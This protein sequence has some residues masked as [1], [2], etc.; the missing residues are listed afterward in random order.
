M[1]GH[2]HLQYRH[3]QG[4]IA[5]SDMIGFLRGIIQT[6]RKAS[7]AET[8]ESIQTGSRELWE[9]GI[10][11]SADWLS[12]VPED[13]DGLFGESP[14]LRFREWIG[15]GR[16]AEA[17]TETSA[18]LPAGVCWAPHAPYTVPAEAWRA[19]GSQPGLQSAHVGESPAEDR[20]FRE[21]EGPL[22]DMILRFGGVLPE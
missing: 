22:A 1:N 5:A 15:L 17:W 11:F 18:E 7:P 10:G 13:G 9:G 12:G 16:G 6:K 4:R 20:L 2:S 3:M 19:L 14:V 21:G 8:A